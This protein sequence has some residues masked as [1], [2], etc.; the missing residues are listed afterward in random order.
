MEEMQVNTHQHAGGE[1]PA[2]VLTR[3][4]DEKQYRYSPECWMRSR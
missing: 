1:A 4:L 3:V 2:R